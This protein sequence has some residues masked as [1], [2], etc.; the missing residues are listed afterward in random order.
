MP[1]A[2]TVAACGPAPARRATAEGWTLLAKAAPFPGAYGFPVHV[3]ADGRFVALHPRGTWSSRDGVAW[4]AEP[5][6]Q[7]GVNHAYHPLV[8]HGGASWSLATITGN[9]EDFAIDPV[10]RRTGDYRGWTVLGR[11]DSLP[12]LVFPAVVSFRGALWLIGGFDGQRY[13][14][15][16]WRSHDGLAWE[17]AARAPWSP[18]TGPR[19]IVFRNR[20]WLIGG[21]TIDG[22]VN[23][24]VWSSADGLNWTME[25]ASLADPQPF[26]FTPQVFD[27]RLWLVG[28]NRSGEF[29]S[30]ML[31]SADGRDWRAVRAPWSPRGAPATWT[32]GKRLYLTGGKYSHPVNGAPRFVYSNDV[33][34]MARSQA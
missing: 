15:A 3:A 7:G 23:S 32:D 8:Q 18:R 30:E 9:Y 19:A 22:P 26:G 10:V 20:L 27:D 17:R 14:D 6:P 16:I 25:A 5:L 2:L 1:P 31:V 11:S 28:A 34:A 33:W 29:A 21:G 12:R 13:G 4:A 24:E